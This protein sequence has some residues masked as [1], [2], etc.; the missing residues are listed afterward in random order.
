M[1]QVVVV[2][3]DLTVEN[4]RQFMILF[5]AVVLPLKVLSFLSKMFVV[6]IIL[7][8]RYRPL[9][10]LFLEVIQSGF[11]QRWSLARMIG[12]ILDVY[13][14]GVGGSILPLSCTK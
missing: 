9:S 5:L 11:A 1:I 4:T 6:L 10:P 3:L 2:N 13:I 14:F 12:K 8:C 7:Y